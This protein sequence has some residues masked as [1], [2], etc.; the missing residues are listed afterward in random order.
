MLPMMEEEAKERKRM[1]GEI[2]GRGMEGKEP[3]ILPAPIEKR[4]SRDQAASL[5]G[6]SGKYVSDLKS[7]DYQKS[8]SALEGSFSF[9]Q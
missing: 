8:P 3:E 9:V 1:N 5:V 4:D 7:I 2:N 6:V